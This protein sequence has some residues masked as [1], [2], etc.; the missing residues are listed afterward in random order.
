MSVYYLQATKQTWDKSSSSD[1]QVF[2][3]GGFWS[4]SWGKDVL[5]TLLIDSLQENSLT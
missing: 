3:F 5:V 4:K 1:S 2:L